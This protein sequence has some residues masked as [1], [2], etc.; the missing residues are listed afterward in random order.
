M[1]NNGAYGRML[2]DKIEKAKNKRIYSFDVMRI[3][4][5]CAVIMI[6]TSAAFVTSRDNA[7]AFLWGNFFNS[8]SR[9]AVPM[10]LMMSGALMLNEDKEISTRKILKSAWNFFVLLVIW[11][12]IYSAGYNIIKPI[13]F[14]EPISITT[15]IKTAF[16]GHY[17]LWYLFVLIGLYILTPILRL[18]IKRENAKLIRNYLLFFVIIG[19]CV[20]FV[21]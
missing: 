14:H 2:M 3:M 15:I 17:H 11:S 12:V 20:P 19:F 1:N 8:I 5:V 16:H 13:V 10:F 9:F 21:N 7:T 4:A 6:H 18:F